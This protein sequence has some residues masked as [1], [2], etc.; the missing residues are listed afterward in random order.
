M[1]HLGSAGSLTGIGPPT[2]CTNSIRAAATFHLKAVAHSS[3]G[4][5]PAPR[6]LPAECALRINI[7]KTASATY[8]RRG[9]VRHF[10]PANSLQNPPQVLERIARTNS[11]RLHHCKD[12]WG[13]PP[14]ALSR[15]QRDVSI[16]KVTATPKGRCALCPRPSRFFRPPSGCQHHLVQPARSFRLLCRN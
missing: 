2:W 15:Q 8:T 13:L 16:A 12:G 1:S 5:C 10:R 6:F 9:S 11:Q 14:T 7:S 4:L 3:T